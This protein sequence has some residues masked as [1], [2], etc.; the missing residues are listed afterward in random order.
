MVTA[1]GRV[2]VVLMGTPPKSTLAG[3][4]AATLTPVPWTLKGIAM[5][6]PPTIGHSNTLVVPLEALV[7]VGV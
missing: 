3:L 2:A 6:L 4:A 1:T 5:Q 7:V